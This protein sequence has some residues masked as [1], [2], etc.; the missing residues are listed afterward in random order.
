MKKNIL[1]AALIIL[2]CACASHKNTPPAISEDTTNEE[3]IS[4]EHIEIPM[5]MAVVEELP[6]PPDANQYTNT[7]A[8]EHKAMALADTTVYLPSQLEVEPYLYHNNQDLALYLKEQVSKAK[9]AAGIKEKGTVTIRALVER[10]GTLTNPVILNSASELLTKHSLAIVKQMPKFR[11]GSL[12][13]WERRA[14]AT[15]EFNW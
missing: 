3:S 12:N 1:S 11:P 5:E 4:L 14:Y 8:A 13:G 9:A 2:C 10:D 15:L 7:T 6:P